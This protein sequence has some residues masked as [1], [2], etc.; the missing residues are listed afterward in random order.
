MDDTINFTVRYAYTND[1]YVRN[2]QEQ[3]KLFELAE[4]ATHKVLYHGVL[5]TNAKYV[6]DILVCSHCG[7]TT[8]HFKF[9][10]HELLDSTEKEIYQCDQCNQYI[11]TH[12]PY[13]DKP[14]KTF[15]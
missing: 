15:L 9:K 3:Y 13:T 11:F 7:A 1:E 8:S 10:I 12:Y 14:C 5:V 6:D 4:K 2:A